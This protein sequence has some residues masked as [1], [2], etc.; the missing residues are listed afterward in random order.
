MGND[1]DAI[2][3][4]IMEGNFDLVVD[5]AGVGCCKHEGTLEHAF[6]EIQHQA[7][8]GILKSG[9]WAVKDVLQRVDVEL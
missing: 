2:D 7:F 5:V 1:D 6:D 9:D 8:G 4:R 3:F